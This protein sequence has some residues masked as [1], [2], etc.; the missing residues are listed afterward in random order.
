MPQST[1]SNLTLKAAFKLNRFI[2]SSLKLLSLSRL[3]PTSFRRQG[4]RSFYEQSQ[5]G[6]VWYLTIAAGNNGIALAF[7]GRVDQTVTA[8]GTLEPMAANDC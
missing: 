6:V 8:S 7:L 4:F 1:E 2:P 3:I 5:H